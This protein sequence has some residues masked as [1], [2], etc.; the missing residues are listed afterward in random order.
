MAQTKSIAMNK[1]EA[2]DDT[3]EAIKLIYPG[4][5]VQ[6]DFG[7]IMLNR[8]RRYRVGLISGGGSGHEPFP[9]GFVGEGMLTAGVVGRIFTGATIANIL[10]AI[11]NVAKL[12]R[13][14]VLLISLNYTTDV[15][16]F[17]A[18][19]E[20]ARSTGY[21]VEILVVSDDVSQVSQ[22]MI[23]IGGRRG[24]VAIVL[25]IKIL[26]GLSSEGKTL[27]EIV[28]VGRCVNQRL[29][30]LGA[31]FESYYLPGKNKPLFTIGKDKVELGTGMHGEP[32]YSQIYMPSLK[33]LI[34]E[35][36]VKLM[37]YLLLEEN[38]QIVVIVNNLG[39]LAQM[40]IH[41]ISQEVFHQ[42][43]DMKLKIE[44]FYVG[45]LVTS[46]NTR[47]FQI[48]ILNVTNQLQWLTYLDEGTEAYAWPGRRI[49]HVIKKY[50]P[51][52]QC[53]KLDPTVLMENGWN[54][55]K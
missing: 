7:L 37:G 48:C 29:A 46:L 55:I 43:V 26:G 45:T 38:S 49:A 21:N 47:G 42:L 10:T 31:T 44:R 33:E 16:N 40:E 28:T 12:N 4:L 14:G 1:D 22:D 50:P 17:S 19:M 11:A 41:I 20:I 6:K 3:L 24:L 23:G 51:Q 54:A 30:T 2:V 35:M 18:A 32:G 13:G 27:C 9:A 15:L 5:F 34:K 36:L 8:E 53:I 39:A 52:L 25:L